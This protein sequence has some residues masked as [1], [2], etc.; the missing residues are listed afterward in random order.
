MKMEHHMLV[1]AP[2]AAGTY[3]I[4]HSWIYTA[5]TIFL[6]FLVDVDHVIDYIREEHRFDM[7]DL[8][9]LYFSRVGIHTSGVDC[10]SVYE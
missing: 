2:I 10:R 7:K 9:L 5:M 4:T 3:F 1:T 8:F 6:G